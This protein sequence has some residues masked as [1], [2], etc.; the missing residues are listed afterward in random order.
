M[1]LPAATATALGLLHLVFAAEVSVLAEGATTWVL[2]M[3]SV[4]GS[5]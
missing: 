1:G 2:C 5:Q 3:V 4:R